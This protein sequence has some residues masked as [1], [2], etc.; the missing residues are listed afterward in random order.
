MKCWSACSHRI[1]SICLVQI[2]LV[3]KCF[4]INKIYSEFTD[5][6]SIFGFK[7]EMWRVRKVS[8]SLGFLVDISIITVLVIIM[9]MR[10]LVGHHVTRKLKVS[11]NL[12][13]RRKF[14]KIGVTDELSEDEFEEIYQEFAFG[15]Y[16]LKDVYATF[17][18][19]M[20]IGTPNVFRVDV[21]NAVCTITIAK[22]KD[23][24]LQPFVLRPIAGPAVAIYQDLQQKKRKE[25]QMKKNGK[26]TE[27]QDEDGDDE[28]NE[29]DVSDKDTDDVKEDV[30]PQPE[31]PAV[32][33]NNLP[34]AKPMPLK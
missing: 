23:M 18:A 10:A 17:N 3:L 28:N 12:N 25:K 21:E 24:E 13:K 1:V 9:A 4:R 31:Q 30:D 33:V 15:Q 32:V 27:N 2:E 34:L 6:D 7:F 11:I 22:E 19:A 5:F 8:T 16:E 29:N 26:S 14:L 20:D